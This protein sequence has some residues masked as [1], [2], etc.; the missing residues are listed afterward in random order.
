MLVFF[1]V[2]DT[3]QNHKTMGIRTGIMLLTTPH[4][5][6]GFSLERRLVWRNMDSGFE[7]VEQTPRSD[8]L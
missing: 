6:L 3:S 1:G 5:Y 2:L 7:L 8:W 4:M